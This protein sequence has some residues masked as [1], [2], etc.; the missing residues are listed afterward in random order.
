MKNRKDFT[1]L[2]LV[3]ELQ[4]ILTLESQRPVPPENEDLHAP[5]FSSIIELF[6][7]YGLADDVFTGSPGPKDATG[8]A[9][10]KRSAYLTH[11]LAERMLHASYGATSIELFN[12][13]YDYL[14]EEDPIQPADLIFVFGAKTP[15]RIEKGVALYNSHCAPLLFISG[16][17][18]IWETAQTPPEALRFKQFAVR[19]GVPESAIITEEKAISMADNVKRSL[20]LMDEGRMSPKKI[21]LVNSPFS[22]RRGWAYFKKWSPSS[23]TLIRVNASAGEVTA[24]ERWYKTE[25]GI[26]VIVNEFVKMKISV[27]LNSA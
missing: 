23:I 20:D 27:A 3:R 13:A 26:R 6:R 2:P 5:D 25:S 10:L 7:F 24:R 22:Q 21:V 17:G 12:K 15:A 8:T 11:E 9:Y 19:N 16:K 18:G 4:K 14:A 1:K